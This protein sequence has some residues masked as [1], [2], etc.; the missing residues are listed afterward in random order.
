MN[1][2]KYIGV[3]IFAAVI[4]VG[5][6]VAYYCYP[7]EIN[8]M[9]GIGVPQAGVIA[10]GVSSSALALDDGADIGSG[11][12]SSV[13]SSSDVDAAPASD[14]VQE[15][16]VDI[17]TTTD[18]SSSSTSSLLTNATDTDVVF[19]DTTSTASTIG[20][21]SQPLS[22]PA[23]SSPSHVLIAAVQTGGASSS[24]DLV[25]LYNPT[26][27]AIDVSGWKLHKK[28]ETG[29]DY[30]LKEF[31]AGS[32]IAAGQFF[33]WA[34]SIGGFSETVDANVS[35]T[36][37]LAADNSV[38]IMDSAGDIVDAVA[39]GTGTSQ[40]GE[41]PPYP[42]SPGANQLLSR[43]SSDGTMADTDNNTN[44]FTLQ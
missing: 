7:A 42:T 36:E 23:V 25:K 37:T 21:S 17:A 3:G 6:G 1:K 14:T 35:S 28:S 30:S 24:N 31:P 41:G 2:K 15:S 5:A 11:A 26:A 44:D 20:S 12:T 16:D 10:D 27:A 8:S 38:A 33:V 40:Y 4:V 18:A 34:N 9:I 29:T 19:A 22:S 43:R 39:W 13:A 32:T